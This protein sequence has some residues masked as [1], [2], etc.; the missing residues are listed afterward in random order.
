MEQARFIGCYIGGHPMDLIQIEKHDLN[1]LENFKY[2]R[3]AGVVLS[4]KE[5]KTR[6]GKLMAFVEI[7]DSTAS[8]ELVIFPSLWKNLKDLNLQETDIISCNVKVEQTDPDIK[9]ILNKI[10]RINTYEMES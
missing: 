7:D 6:S 9:L 2:A 1:S 5:I 3:V 10:Q 4:I 8:A